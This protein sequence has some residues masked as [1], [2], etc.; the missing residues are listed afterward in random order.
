MRRDPLTYRHPRTLI[1]AFGCDA[2]SANPIEGPYRSEWE[3]LAAV[4]FAIA[5]GLM[6]AWGLYHYFGG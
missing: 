1:E 6:L 5:I 4:L 3:G 2:D